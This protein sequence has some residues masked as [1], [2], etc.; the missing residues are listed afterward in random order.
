MRTFAAVLFT[1]AVLGVACGSSGRDGFSGASVDP[2]EPAD[3]AGAGPGLGTNDAQAKPPCKGLACQRVHCDGGATTSV[4]GVVWDPAGKNPL[5]NVTV[6]VPDEPLEE[7][8]HGPVCNSC[9]GAA[10][11]GKPLVATLTDPKGAF[12]LDNVPIG[13]SIPLVMQIGKW[14]R[15]VKISV[16]QACTDNVIMDPSLTRLPRN[17]Q[18]GDMPRIALTAGCDHLDDL[19]KKIGIESAEFTSGTGGGAVH[20]YSTP[21]A[22]TTGPIVNAGVTDATDAY[23]LWGSLD[24]MMKYDLIINS[25]ECTPRPR[26]THGPAYENVRLYLNAGGRFFASHYHLNFFGSSPEA[27]NKAAP[28]FQVSAVWALWGAAPPSQ[29]P[30][31]IDTS[32]PKGKA[33]DEWLT[34]LP[35]VSNWG[36][37]IKLTPNGQIKVTNSRDIVAAVQDVSQRWIYPSGGDGAVYLSINTP[38]TAPPAARC[39][40]AVLTDLHVGNGLFTNMSEQEAALE[41]MFFD[42]ASCVIDD[43]QPPVP[44]P[45]VK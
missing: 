4:S 32:F 9:G 15:Q 1:S 35:S 41:F 13:G 3:A 34:H 39:G 19:I 25:C 31:M 26:D 8:K 16:T 10:I 27:P 6:Y 44:P 17:Q 36:P 21:N 33:L 29:A 11:S 23:E 42:L 14:R 43:K 22:S 30:F 40:R 20:V 28:E 2:V 38:T 18:Q 37:T 7:I 12:K 24:Q 45:V 5:Y